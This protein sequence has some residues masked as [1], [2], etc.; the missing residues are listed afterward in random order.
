MSCLSVDQLFVLNSEINS[1]QFEKLAIQQSNLGTDSSPRLIW[2]SHDTYL[3]E[4][5]SNDNRNFYIFKRY[6]NEAD[7]VLLKKIESVLAFDLET[8]EKKN[9]FI[10]SKYIGKNELNFHT[11][12]LQSGQERLDFMVSASVKNN[13]DI[14]N[15]KVSLTEKNSKLSMII[16]CFFSDYSFTVF[17]QKGA[18]FF[19]REESLAYIVGVEMID[20]PLFHLQEE[21]EDEFG[22]TTQ[23]NIFTMFYKR[24]RTQ[25]IMLKEFVLVDSVQKLKN[26]LVQDS[27]S[28]SSED[29]VD[30]TLDE[31]TRDEFNLNKVIVCVTS[32]GKVFGIYTSSNGKILWSFFLKNTIPFSVNKITN[33]NSAPLFVQR[34]AAHVP[35]EPQC[36]V[37]TKIKDKDVMK[38]RVVFFNP[39][40]GKFSKDSPKEG[41]ILEKNAKQ[42]F[43]SSFA[44]S[45][46]LKPVIVMDETN[47][48]HV[49]PESSID[50]IKTKY[51][52][53]PTII[54]TS[55]NQN[56]KKSFLTGYSMKLS[57]EVNFLLKDIFILNLCIYRTYWK[58]GD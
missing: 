1:S 45:H 9:F 35:Y 23:D 10:Y 6:G 54:F 15:M 24:I 32:I 36:A 56:E 25:L 33:E 37:V 20:F 47:H 53:K 39:L 7:L 11:I 48:V 28:R 19:T 26:F 42:V 44:D 55:Q 5:T 57:N 4:T 34:T 14:L 46:F 16:S 43:L 30:I 22:T 51:G 21:F 12:D 18:K 31:I 17:N 40:T 13:Q 29:S 50:D 38:T 52:N 27:P 2:S 41:F 8:S 49:F 58:F 3:L